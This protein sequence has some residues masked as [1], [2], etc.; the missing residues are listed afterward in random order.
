MSIDLGIY[1]LFSF[2]I[3]GLL[4]LYAFNEFSR[5]IGWKF[6]DIISWVIPGQTPSLIFFIPI[7]I[8]AY[9]AGHLLDLVSQIFFN[10]FPIFSDRLE[11]NNYWYTHAIKD[12]YP[13]LNI[14]FSPKDRNLLFPLIRQRNIEMARVLDG[15]SAN[16]IMFRNIAF[17]FFL[18]S[19]TNFVLLSKTKILDFLFVALIF[20]VLSLLSILSSKKYKEWFNKDVFR[21]S[22][23]YGVNIEDVVGYTRSKEKTESTSLTKRS[24]QGRR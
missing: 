15:Y 22:L 8:G 9:L 13:S 20:L 3:P 4:Y 23:E 16:S 2:I 5:S 18:L 17:G 24:K 21:A 12:R 10:L 19:T 11:R 6:V 7:L 1:D 14:Q